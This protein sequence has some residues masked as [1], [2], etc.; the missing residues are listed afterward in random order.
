MSMATLE[1]AILKNARVILAN[2]NLK[3]SDIPVWITDGDAVKKGLLAGEIAVHIPDPGV[4]I[5][6]AQEKDRRAK[7]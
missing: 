3:M 1:C 7:S 2:P 4:W 6:V 5:A